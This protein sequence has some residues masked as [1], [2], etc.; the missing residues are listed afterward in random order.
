MKLH[1]IKR[2]LCLSPLFVILVL[3]NPLHS[4]TGDADVSSESIQPTVLPYGEWISPITTDLIVAESIRVSTPQ[5]DGNDI[6]WLEGRPQEA[7]RSVLVRRSAD[8]VIED[9]TPPPFN[10]RSRVHEYGGGPYL[11]ADGVIYFSNFTDQRIYRHTHG[12]NPVAITPEGQMRY[13]DYRLVPG[14][15]LMAAIREDHSAEGEPVN[16]LVMLNVEEPGS[17]VVLAGGNDFYSA[18]RVSPDGKQL[19]WLTWNHPNMPWDGT[20]LW[21]ADINENG[22][23]DNARLVTGG[24]NESVFQP[25]WSP[26]GTLHFV[27]DRD[28]WWN[29]FRLNPDGADPV[30]EPLYPMD[31]EFGQP[32]WGFG[33]STYGFE[34]DDSIICVYTV[35]ASDHLARLNT[36]SKRFDDIDS[37]YT[38]INSIRVSGDRALFLGG[39]PSRFSGLVLVKTHDAE[40]GLVLRQSTDVTVDEGYIS[41]AQAIEF[42]TEHGL[43]AHAFYYAPHNHNFVAPEGTLPP[44]LVLSHGGPTGATSDTMTLPILFWTSRGI[45]VVDVNYG[46]STGYGR[47]Y[48]KRLNGKWGIVDVDDSVNATKYLVARGLADGE[49]LA[50]RGGSAGGYTTL[51]SLTFRDVFKAGASYFGISDLELLVRDTHKFESR[52][53]DSM[54][55]PYPQSLETY[56][57]RSPIHHI[58]SLNSP[59]IFLQGL[60]DRVVPPNQ[61]EIM[62]NELKDKGV[63]TAYLPFEGEGHGFRQAK[64]QKRAL[65]AELYFYGKILGFTPAGDLEPVE[66]ANSN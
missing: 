55:G 8:G 47:A 4:D 16:T 20:E 33:M 37:P 43:T 29:L 21:L 9:M 62:F 26:G 2:S 12:E 53:I 35:N 46:G 52:Y 54:V 18:P 31:A 60:E 30:I 34:A 39:A 5:F 24:I 40:D 6:Y 10:V 32:M 38:N 61:A 23:L 58:E 45:A 1:G 59:V 7:G 44:L 17:G 57:E 22:L 51:A 63:Q 42:P 27:T 19:A 11:V 50:I 48:R 65:D 49:R 15:S 66:I 13:A 28:G 41:Q 36:T 3:F 64:N 14:T 25:E 56:Q